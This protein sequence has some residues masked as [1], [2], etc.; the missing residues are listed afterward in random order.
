MAPLKSF[1]ASANAADAL[2]ACENSIDA[3]VNMEESKHLHARGCNCKLHI[4]LTELAGS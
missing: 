3:C 2:F 4:E 1:F